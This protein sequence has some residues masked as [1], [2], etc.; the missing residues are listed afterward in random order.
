[1]MKYA[2]CSEKDLRNSLKGGSINYHRK[3]VLMLGD[4]RFAILRSLFGTMCLLI[5][6]Y[7]PLYS[8]IRKHIVHENSLA[9]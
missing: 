7:S 4:L 9:I 5:Q 8:F 1:M 6:S 3:V 2:I